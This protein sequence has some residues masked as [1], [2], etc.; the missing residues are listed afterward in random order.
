MMTTGNQP[1]LDDLMEKSSTKSKRLEPRPA[2]LAF[3]ALSA[4]QRTSV[5]NMPSLTSSSFYNELFRFDLDSVLSF[6]KHVCDDGLCKRFFFPQEATVGD[7][8]S[9]EEKDDVY[10]KEHGHNQVNVAKMIATRL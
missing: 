10:A 9:E 4:L 6:K 2:S 3:N 5:P 7:N 8:G 1:S